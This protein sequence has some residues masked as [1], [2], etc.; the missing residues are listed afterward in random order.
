MA[1][2]AGNVKELRELTGAGMMD[3]KK[4]LTE[5]NGDMEQAIEFLRKKGLAASAKKAGR[6]AAEGIVGILID[7]NNGKASIVEVNSETDFVAK[8]DKFKAFVDNVN[9]Q[10]LLSS[11]NDV[12]EL[13]NEKWICDNTKTVAEE[14]SSQVAV[15]GENINI[16]RFA[17][18][19]NVDAVLAGYIHGE[20]RIG[21]LLEANAPKNNDKVEE[22][23]SDVCMQI[24]AMNP[25]CV[26]E[27]DVPADY[28]EH[29]KS[30]LLEQA[31]N[32]NN[33][34]PEN[35]RKPEAIIEKMLEGRMNK[36]LKEICLLDQVYVKNGDF[37]V[38]SY[39][40]SVAK[41]VGADITINK[42]VRF[43][44]GE[45]IEK[46]EENFA[47]EVAAQMNM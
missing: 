27:K 15:I 24:A 43:E 46:K 11:A 5:T 29:E 6:I 26:S 23:L 47:A 41:E 22:L 18:F 38:G 7:S 36:Q 39:I 32:E 35:K 33:K 3:C 30:I 1:F 2:T 37:T 31:I 40:A 42:F 14:V 16:R 12:E 20:G 19:E 17:R 4:A 34:L 45:G 10:V 9:E 44:T 25:M 21:V 13:K 8:N 28:I